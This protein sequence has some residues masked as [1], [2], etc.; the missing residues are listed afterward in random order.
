M[1]LIKKFYDQVNTTKLIGIFP[2][3]FFMFTM[4]L[5]KVMH[6]SKAYKIQGKFWNM[7]AGLNLPNLVLSW[8]W[9]GLGWFLAGLS[10]PC[11]DPDQELPEASLNQFIIRDC[12]WKYAVPDSPVLWHHK[13]CPQ[14]LIICLIN[15][16]L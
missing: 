11:A 5:I 10:L 13:P 15:I 12:I 4:M 1:T 9:A 7:A 6:L 8:S 14:L 3:E 16:N 2:L